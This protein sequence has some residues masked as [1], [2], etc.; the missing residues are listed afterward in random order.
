[1]TGSHLRVHLKQHGG[2]REHECKVCGKRFLRR[3]HLKDHLLTHTGQKPY[4]CVVCGKRYTQSGHVK[5]HMKVHEGGG[6]LL[7]DADVGALK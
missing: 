5:R 4:E 2:E 7:K 1:M 6:G 3:E